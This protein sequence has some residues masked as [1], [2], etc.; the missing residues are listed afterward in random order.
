MNNCLI[1]ILLLSVLALGILILKLWR[2]R[3]AGTSRLER[4]STGFFR[5][6]QDTQFKRHLAYGDKRGASGESENSQ[7]KRGKGRAKREVV[8]VLEFH[9]DLRCKQH[10]ALASFVDEI[11]V[12]RENIQ[13]VVV[14][15]HSPGGMVGPYGHAFAQMERLRELI[16][17]LTMCVDVVAASGGY[18][19]CL[20]AHKV[21]AAPFS[22]VGSVGV[23]AFV[24]N[25]RRLLEQWQVAP[26]TFL[27][28]KFKQPVSLTDNA[29]PED[30]A[31]FQEQ[32]ETVHDLF[33]SA[34]RKYRPQAKL[35]EIETGDHWT[36]IESLEKNLGLVDEIN[37][38]QAY[39]IS[40]NKAADLI[41]ISHK[42]SW[43]DDNLS[44]LASSAVDQ[45]ENRL[46]SLA[47]GW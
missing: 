12:N 30:L 4:D 24:P 36:A 14:V 26:R 22:L 47:Q 9:G 15:M 34:V 13:E 38:S 19:M 17:Q 25:V 31:R 7:G 35:E 5:Y 16:P 46:Y 2:Q 23:M 44:F 27:A 28:G 21:I 29:S 43:W 37:T 40:K 1:Y 18:L 33:L 39:L 10:R 45:V 32:L 20:P 6:H 11:E 42:K 8:A 41:Y 3:K